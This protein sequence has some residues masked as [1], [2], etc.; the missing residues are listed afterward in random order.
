MSLNFPDTTVNNPDTGAAWAQG[1]TVE[2]SGTVYTFNT[3]AGP[4]VTT[5]WSGAAGTNLDDRYVLEAGDTMTGGLYQTVRNI[6]N[7]TAWDMST[8]NLWVTA[9]DAA[10]IAGPT[11]ATA[12]MSGVIF[13]TAEVTAWG[14]GNFDFPGG[15]TPATIPANSVVPYYVRADNVICIGNATENVT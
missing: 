12:G 15:A 9:A 3:D 1:D 8:G 4:P 2:I 10:T 5:W 11:N 7:N 6:A 13:C 14:G